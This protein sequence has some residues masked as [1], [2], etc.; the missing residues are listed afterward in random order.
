M[1][2]SAGAKKKSSQL[3]QK[4]GSQLTH[5]KGSHLTHHND[6]RI[7][8]NLS[9]GDSIAAKDCSEMDRHSDQRYSYMSCLL[10]TSDA[11]DE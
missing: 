4:K 11:A 1:C 2:I 7:E 6:C 3:T 5:K 8:R 9:A 10:Y